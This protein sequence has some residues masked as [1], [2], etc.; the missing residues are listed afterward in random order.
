[1]RNLSQTARRRPAHQL[2]EPHL[3]SSR[4]VVGLFASAGGARAGGLRTY[5]GRE[6]LCLNIALVFGRTNRSFRIR[7]RLQPCRYRRKMTAREG[8]TRTELASEG[9]RLLFFGKE[10]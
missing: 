1:Q 4:P 9:L 8:A 6:P 10:C 2:A 3:P 7:A 5:C